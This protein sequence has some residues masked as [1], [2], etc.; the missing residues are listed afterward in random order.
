M[1][2]NSTSKEGLQMHFK[3]Q[4]VQQQ[5]YGLSYRATYHIKNT[6]GGQRLLNKEFA[7][8]RMK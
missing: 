5:K 6:S 7:V 1:T 8:V 2:I 4:N 3:Q